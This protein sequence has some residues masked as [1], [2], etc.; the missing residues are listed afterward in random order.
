MKNIVA[1]IPKGRFKTWPLAE[2]VCKQCDGETMRQGKKWY[3]TIRLPRVPMENLIGSV[4]YM[5]YDGQVRGYF[6]IVDL[7]DASNWDW[8]N[9]RGQT[10]GKVLVMVNWTSVAGL[11]EQN[12]FQGWRYTALRP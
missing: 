5:I 4:C 8:H 6:H 2:K 1:T 9:D 7:D 10:S 12:G 11:P 3:W